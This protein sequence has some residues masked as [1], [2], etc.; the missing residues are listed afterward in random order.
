[1]K[2]LIA[3]IMWVC[4]M[5]FGSATLQSVWIIIIYSE[6]L[7]GITTRSYSRDFGLQ[8]YADLRL[9]RSVL[10]QFLDDFRVAQFFIRS[11]PR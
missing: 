11:C 8:S 4:Q 10:N 2:K 9:W 6:K 1:M 7:K 5:W 3:G